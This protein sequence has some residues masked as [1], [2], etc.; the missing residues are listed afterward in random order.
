M[1]Q[2]ILVGILL[3]AAIIYVVRMVV[4]SVKSDG[5]DCPD[6]EVGQ[7]TKVAGRKS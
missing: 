6:C 2:Y 7:K 4:R 1:W 3:L 5:H